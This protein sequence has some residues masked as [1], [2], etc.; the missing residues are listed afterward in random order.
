MVLTDIYKIFEK[1]KRNMEGILNN[2]H[3]LALNKKSEIKGAVN[4]IDIFLKTLEHFQNQ[5]QNMPE[6]NL[7]SAPLNEKKGLFSKIFK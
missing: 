5:P 2:G 1:R 7:E 3:S 4:E 6:I